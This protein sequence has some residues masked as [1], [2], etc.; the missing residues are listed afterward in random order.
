MSER[1]VKSQVTTFFICVWLTLQA[2]SHTSDQRRRRQVRKDRFWWSDWVGARSKSY[3]F[4]GVQ[5][6]F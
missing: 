3:H 2:D 4:D 1:L 5:S 6:A